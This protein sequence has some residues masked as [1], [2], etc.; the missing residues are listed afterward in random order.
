MV[1]TNDGEVMAKVL[2][3]KT[4]RQRRSRLAE[5]AH[6][7]RHLAASDIEWMGRIIWASQ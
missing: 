5:P 3:K 4:A 2:Q 6:K 7:E 1:K